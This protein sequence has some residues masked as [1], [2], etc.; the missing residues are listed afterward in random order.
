MKSK[1]KL[2]EI[3]REIN[4]RLVKEIIGFLFIKIFLQDLIKVNIETKKPRMSITGTIL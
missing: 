1:T 4:G 2:I 3:K